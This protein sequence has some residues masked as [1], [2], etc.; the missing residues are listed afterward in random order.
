MDTDASV[1]DRD[2]SRVSIPL[3]CPA[4][5]LTAPTARLGLEARDIEQLLLRAQTDVRAQIKASSNGQ[6]RCEDIRVGYHYHFVPGCTPQNTTP[7]VDLFMETEG[8]LNA[9]TTTV[10]APG[11][12]CFWWNGRHRTVHVVAEVERGGLRSMRVVDI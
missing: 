4:T 9:R 6:A 11:M 8:D 12:V 7:V 1:G 10:E 2:S 5:P 3:L